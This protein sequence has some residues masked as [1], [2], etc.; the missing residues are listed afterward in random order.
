M[1]TVRKKQC[2]S[3]Q[4]ILGQDLHF[5]Y[6]NNNVS[7]GDFSMRPPNWNSSANMILTELSF[8]VQQTL[9][10]QSTVEGNCV[11][12]RYLFTLLLWLSSSP[13]SALQHILLLNSF[14]RE[15]L[16]FQIPAP[17]AAMEGSKEAYKPALYHSK[18]SGNDLST[19][20]C[21]WIPSLH[22]R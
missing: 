10:V 18:H 4:D 11:F 21:D 12:L 16:K 1:I 13:P 3:V 20:S 22:S 5:L 14:S 9:E 15:E 19:V 2:E 7:K 6:A 17:L 8:S